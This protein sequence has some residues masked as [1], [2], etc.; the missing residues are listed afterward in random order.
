[1]ST[2]ASLSF[3]HDTLAQRVV[4]DTGRAVDAVLDQAGQLGI[5]RPLLVSTDGTHEVA[6]TIA[7]RLT[8]AVHWRDAVQHVPRHI[9]D[10]EDMFTS[11]PPPFR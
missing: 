7:G 2:P 5:T 8:P 6:E 9:A 1:M 11:V 3:V 4:F 10:A